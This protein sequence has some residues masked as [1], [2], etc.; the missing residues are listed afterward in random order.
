MEQSGFLDWE[1]MAEK[2]YS[3]VVGHD[4]KTREGG[5]NTCK[6]GSHGTDRRVGLKTGIRTDW[7]SKLGGIDRYKCGD[8]WYLW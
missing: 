8:G 6:V 3:A 2:Q 4:R 7:S 5:L 1:D